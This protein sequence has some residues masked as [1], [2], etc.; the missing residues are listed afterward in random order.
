MK[1][2]DLA[3][4]GAALEASLRRRMAGR[5]QEDHNRHVLRLVEAGIR[6]G[7]ASRG[8]FEIRPLKQ[9]K[10]DAVMEEIVRAYMQSEFPRYGRTDE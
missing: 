8:L 9:E 7:W 4:L 1:K 6:Y 10:V 2:A 3:A 5:D